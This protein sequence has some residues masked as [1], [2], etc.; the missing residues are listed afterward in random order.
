MR[1]WDGERARVLPKLVCNAR[2]LKASSNAVENVRIR[3][4]TLMVSQLVWVRSAIRKFNSYNAKLCLLTI[5]W[6]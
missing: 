4:L 3:R 6:E 5:E 2:T 1:P